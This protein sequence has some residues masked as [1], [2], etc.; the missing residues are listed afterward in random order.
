MFK[1]P[2]SLAN[3]PVP[4]PWFHFEELWPLSH[5]ECTKLRDYDWSIRRNYNLLRP[6]ESESSHKG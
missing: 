2:S 5:V 1:G 6:L 4:Q 3:R